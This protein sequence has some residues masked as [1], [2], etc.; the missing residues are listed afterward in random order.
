LMTLLKPVFTKKTVNEWL[1]LIGDEF[2]CGPINNLGQVFSMSQ[3]KERDM[4]IQ[5]K[6]PTIGDLP[7]VGSPLKFS[8]TPVAYRQPPPL[9]GEHTE[10]VLIDL[11]GY[12]TAQIQDLE[13]RGVIK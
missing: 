6:H 8:E 13:L 5:M 9:K 12:S 1:A 2:P 4:L 10:R 11:L 7:L 3:V